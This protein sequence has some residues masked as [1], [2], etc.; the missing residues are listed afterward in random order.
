MIA[1]VPETGSTNGE[2]A[3]RIAGGEPV[4]EG[5]WLVADRQTAGRGRQGRAWLD[6]AGNFMGSTVVHARAGDPPL[7]SLAL[8]AGLAVHAALAPLVPPPLR[9]EIKWP[10]DVLVAGAKLAG[11]LL[12]RTGDAV[13]V[14]I[15]ANLALAPQVPGRETVALSAFGPAPD[16]DGFTQ[17]LASAFAAE[18]ALWRAAGL[19]ALVARWTIA[20]HPAG[21]ALLV[22]EPG[23]APLAGTFAG[24]DSTGALILT[25]GDGTKRTIQAGEVRLAPPGRAE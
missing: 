21:T 20:A 9:A 13:I 8:V 22:G 6:G 3:A 17:A 23:E 24:L 25:L 19:E 10:N 15:G 12:E 14:G 11:V 18:L 16:R 7:P 4:P 2:I 5:D 1:F